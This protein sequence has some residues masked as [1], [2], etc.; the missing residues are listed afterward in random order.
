[1][2]NIVA[3]ML[4]P[5]S[6]VET[7][8]VHN[9]HRMATT[10]LAD[11]SVRPQADPAALEE[12]KI[13]LVKQL[14]HHHETEDHNLWPLIEKAAPGAS[15]PLARLS[16]EHHALDQALDDLEAAAAGSPELASAAETVRRTVHE[17]LE[18]EEPILFPALREHV[19]EQEWKDFSAFVMATTPPAGAHLAVGFFGRVASPDEI[20]VLFAGLPQPVQEAGPALAKQ[21]E[22][23]ITALGGI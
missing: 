23:T 20:Q 15:A 3:S 19:T 17:H 18:H 16:D 6:I 7:R 13:F 11:A 9:M 12:L 1:M 4:D 14:R 10:L 22:E 21:A 2:I 8:V 5:T